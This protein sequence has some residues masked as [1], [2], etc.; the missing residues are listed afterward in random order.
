MSLVT[1]FEFRRFERLYAARPRGV[2][3]RLYLVAAVGIFT[4]FTLSIVG[5]YFAGDMRTRAAEVRR[6]DIPIVR[7]LFGLQQS[8]VDH[9]YAIRNL[10][11]GATTGVDSATIAKQTAKVI[12]ASAANE[13]Y[14]LAGSLR[15]ALLRVADQGETLTSAENRE[16]TES[17]V[18]F[19]TYLGRSFEAEAKVRSVLRDLT[20]Q[21][22]N[23]V[24]RIANAG[25]SL[26]VW[27]LAIL[28]FV[29]VCVGPMALWVVRTLVR[30]INRVTQTMQRI[31]DCETAVEVPSTVDFDEIGELAR[32]VQV[33]KS[34]TIALLRNNDEIL[35]LNGWF[36]LAM[37]NM[38][39]GMSIFDKENRL[40][41]CNERYREIYD[42]PTELIRPGTPFKDIEGNCMGR[43]A[44]RSIVDL[45]EVLKQRQAVFA[46]GGDFVKIYALKDGRVILVSYRPLPEGGWVDMHDD[47]TDHISSEETI[48]RLVR[49]D[50]LTGLANRRHFLDTIDTRIDPDKRDERYALIL[51]D[52]VAFQRLNEAIGP[53]AGDDL[54]CR[55]ARNIES[56]TDIDGIAARFGSDVFGVYARESNAAGIVASVRKSLA[57][58]SL[59]LPQSMQL[60]I[61]TSMA[62]WPDHGATAEDLS[63]RAELALVRAKSSGRGELVVFA[64]DLESEVRERQALEADLLA[65]F[66]QGQLELFY[67]PIV[68]YKSRR[69]TS[70][71]ALMRWRHPTRGLVPP[72]LF[73]PVAE[74]M[75]L[76][77]QLG[78][79]AI[80]QAC[81]DL[82]RWPDHV[83]VAVNLSAAQF[84][85]C[86]LA[87]VTQKALADAG[88]EASRLAF[89]V[90][91]SLLLQDEVE[92]RRTL[93]R[94]QE[95]GVAIALDDF[96]TGYAS[97]SY[98][99]SF[100]FDKIK[101]DQ[102]FVRDLPSRSDCDAIVT[103]VVS[104]ARK[105]GMKT[106]AEGVS[107][108]L[109]FV[110]VEAAGC[111]EI[112]G[113]Y[114]S[115]AVPA[116]EVDD[117]IASCER[118]IL[119]AA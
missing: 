1:N 23:K 32:A 27:I 111:D 14:P 74:E 96:G 54:L 107:S 13:T 3:A 112:Q 38:V 57:E 22:H 55:I 12:K 52:I 40:V 98:L 117:V 5:L 80:R 100:P 82:R 30:R 41:M 50:Q 67:Q 88:V 37:D 7:E 101:I 36:D 72:G 85:G 63:H 109:H 19:E 49:N 68:D 44:Q 64:F 29:I 4:L 110:K 102:T 86:D 18:Q 93:L 16:E 48:Q 46:E 65:G 28:A 83:H 89:E 61:A 25:D 97:L 114:L 95:L 70:L 60:D 118:R 43:M 115:P 71:E 20:E 79:W 75:G 91:E 34:N 39:R 33:F 6:V 94:L 90:T 116:D 62:V 69:V 21:A 103:S 104:L 59:V 66:A 42:L 35:R 15:A 78:E 87:E 11:Q 58:I 31:A 92:T 108:D 105:L 76:I 113:F 47:V 17:K 51:F 99:R 26:V 53:K 2:A 8:I 9:R 106:V 119:A 73:I 10:A 56:A 84:D 24:Q 45:S 81:Q 77:V